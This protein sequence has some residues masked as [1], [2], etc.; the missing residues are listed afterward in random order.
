MQIDNLSVSDF[1]EW[2]EYYN[3]HTQRTIFQSPDIYK[4][5]KTVE[6]YTPI[7]ILVRN[8]QKKISGVLLILIIKLINL[9]ISRLS[10]WGL[11]YGRPLIS[12]EDGLSI[13]LNTVNLHI[14]K[15]VSYIQ[16][17]F[18]D[19][20]SDSE[21]DV[22]LRSG[23]NSIP[24][25][26]I[27]VKT[28]NINEVKNGLSESKRRQIRL[29]QKSEIVIR[30]PN[31]SN[32]VHEFY[33]ILKNLYKTKVK[34]PLPPYS[35]FE[36]FYELSSNGKIGIIKLAFHEG[37]V[38]GGII[39]AVTK[40]LSAHEWYIAGMEEFNKQYYTS[41][42]I[43]W[44]V[45]EY[46][47]LNNYECFDFLGSGSPTKDSGVRNFKMGFSQEIINTYRFDKFSFP[48]YKISSSKYMAKKIF[49]FI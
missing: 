22:F 18:Y 16:F 6:R 29:S 30:L 49:N 25:T 40:G 21:K 15:K 37:K 9:P 17:R 26:N 38:I 4:F 41:V 13:L 7:A 46:A 20:V 1:L 36:N 10:S 47:V 27:K 33:L 24:W 19:E 11:V 32:E 48:I 12:M 23:F 5:Y 34:K 2:E 28:D 43:T 35:F 44:N 31:N 8:S 39:V 14:K 45:I 42:S 3:S